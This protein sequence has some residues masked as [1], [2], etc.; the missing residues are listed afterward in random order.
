MATVAS[1]KSQE[2]RIRTNG[3]TLAHNRKLSL[4]KSNASIR[5]EWKRWV[6]CNLPQK[7]I[8]IRKVSRITTPEGFLSGLQNSCAREFGFRE[9]CV[10]LVTSPGIICERHSV[11]SLAIDGN[12]RILG[13][14]TARVQGQSHSTGLKEDDAFLVRHRAPPSQA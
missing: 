6:P 1:V 9:H 4:G 5:R 3:G 12:I 10:Y 2:L 14:I 8:R 11:E 7:S 13:Q